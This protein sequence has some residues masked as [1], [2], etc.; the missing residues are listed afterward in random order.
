MSKEKT[1]KV[2]IISI[3]EIEMLIFEINCKLD[4]KREKKIDIK[5][6]VH[7]KTGRAKEL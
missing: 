7:E 6:I 2:I 3:L 5:V 1:R 4:R